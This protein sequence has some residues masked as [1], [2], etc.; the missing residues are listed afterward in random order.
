VLTN[1][2]EAAAAARLGAS[3]AVRE[4]SALMGLLRSCFARTQTW[5]QAGKYLNALVS[6]LPSRNGGSAAEHAGASRE[7][8]PDGRRLPGSCWSLGRRHYQTYPPPS[9]P[10]V[11]GCSHPCRRRR[12]GVREDAGEG[13]RHV[14]GWPSPAA[15]S[16]LAEPLRG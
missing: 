8:F 13:T 7:S 9:G 11:S 2:N 16:L 5:L 6:E 10:Q 15:T 3:R 4:R 14:Q 1:E 12:R